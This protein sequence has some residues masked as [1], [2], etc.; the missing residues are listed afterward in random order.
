MHPT[1]PTLTRRDFV[2]IGGALFVSVTFGDRA[3]ATAQAGPAGSRST[4]DATRLASW[5]EIRD[6]GSILARTGRAE[7]GVNM[8]AYYAQMI[9]EELSVRP[10]TITLVMGDTDRTPDGGWSADFLSGAQNLRKVAAYTHQALL[11]LAARHLGAAAAEL[12]VAGGVVSAGGRRVSYAELVRGQ[13][14]DLTIPVTGGL[15]KMNDKRTAIMNTFGIAVAGDPP[16]KPVSKYTVVGTSFPARHIAD[17]VTMKAEWVGDLRLPGMLHGRMVRPSTLGSTLVSIGTLDRKRFPTAEVITKLNLV[18]VVSPN[19]WEAV[20]AA[21]ALAAQTRW[22]AW[23]GL[24][25]SDQIA[26]AVKTDRKPNASQG[27]AAK[28][29][30]AFAGAAR[31]VAVTYE[32]P[33]IKH[34]PIGPYCAVADVK[35]DGTTTVWTHSA[36]SSGLRAHLANMMSVDLEKV[37]V[38]WLEGA[39]QYGRTSLGGDGAEADAVILSQMTG[40]PVRV[41]WTMQED[42]AWSSASPGWVADLRAALDANGKLMALTSDFYT[43][44]QSDQRMLGAVLAGLPEI[45]VVPYVGPATFGFGAVT[46]PYNVPQTLHRAFGMANL[47]VDAPSGVGLRSNIFRTPMQRQHVFALESLLNE[48]AAAA[49]ADPI[50]FRLDHTSD[51][52]LID[53]IRKTAEAAGWQP[54][55]S[56]SPSARRAGST[57]VKG[58]G[59]AVMY[60]FGTYWA[61]IAEVEVTPSTGVVKVTHFTLGIDPGKVINPRHLKL[62]A[63]GGVVMGLGEA[64]KEEMTFDKEKVTATNW[65]RYRIPTMADLPELRIVTISRDD[66]GFGGGG[67]AAN[68]LPQPALV[69]AVF[70]ATGVQPRRTPLTPASVQRLL[71][72]A[73]ELRSTNNG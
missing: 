54:R 24:P 66:Q 27:D 13:Q 55:P 37:T 34:A 47:G 58:R 15:A 44:H 50:Q 25:G 71:A 9:A 26:S 10:E 6:D 70:D 3:L 12:S 72:G 17:K 73:A 31:T 2:R 43:P 48:A 36:Q 22:T 23:S 45:T 33:F 29:E 28:T 4:L 65:S 67:E 63:E 46:M 53:V 18:G 1:E 51:S 30:A 52:R 69:A 59:M 40:R 14:L 61:A 32:Q 60:R 20:S 62:I 39:G 16:M 41:E 11:G 49:G 21:R 38:R 19:E 42:L 68:S 8:S 5:L 35:A 56:P 57:P 64:L 7:M